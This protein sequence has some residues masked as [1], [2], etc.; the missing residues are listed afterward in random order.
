[1]ARVQCADIG[2]LIANGNLAG[3]VVGTLLTL[4]ASGKAVMADAATEIVVAILAADLPSDKNTTDREISVWPINKAMELPVLA[5]AAITR[6][7]VLIPTTTD[8][9]AAGVDGT[10][11]LANDQMGFGIAMEAATAADQVITGFIM[12]IAAPHQG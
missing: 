9:K 8:G 12:P 2:T 7:H 1:M 3:E 5:S 11:G 4:N 6:G 10:G